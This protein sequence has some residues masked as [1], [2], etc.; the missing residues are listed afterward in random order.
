MKI[1]LEHRLRSCP[2]HLGCISCGQTFASN[3][4]RALLCRDSGLIEG[5]LCPRCIKQG[6]D[7]IRLNLRDRATKL[8]LQLDAQPSPESQARGFELRAVAA[9]ALTMPPAYQWWL[10]KLEIFHTESRELE[11]ARRGLKKPGGKKL[12]ITFLEEKPSVGQDA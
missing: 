8:M 12:Q 6:A 7:R 10:K 11:L 9:E 1:Q 2:K 5:D 3:R 4:L